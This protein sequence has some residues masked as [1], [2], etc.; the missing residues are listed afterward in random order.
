MRS[1]SVF[2][3]QKGVQLSEIKKME[4]DEFIWVSNELFKQNDP[5]E[6]KQTQPIGVP[7][8]PEDDDGA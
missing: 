4:W 5:D 1:L 6:Y 8:E 2:M 3:M 7:V